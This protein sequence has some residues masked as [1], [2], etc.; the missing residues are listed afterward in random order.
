M[1]CAVIGLS[2]VRGK[3]ITMKKYE[4]NIM[5]GCIERTLQLISVKGTDYLYSH[6]KFVKLAKLTAL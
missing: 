3:T 4:G 6:P 2:M 5:K 1:L